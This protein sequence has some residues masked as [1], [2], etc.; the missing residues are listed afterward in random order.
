MENVPKKLEVSPWIEGNI[1][2]RYITCDQGHI[3]LIV[4]VHMGMVDRG[5]RYDNVVLVRLFHGLV[6]N[7]IVVVVGIPCCGYTP[8]L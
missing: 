1:I 3:E 7:N 4:K 6:G 2:H 5:I 8:W